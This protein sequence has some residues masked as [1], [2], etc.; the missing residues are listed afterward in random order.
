[1]STDQPAPYGGADSGAAR[2]SGTTPEPLTPARVRTVHLQRCKDRGERF[3]MLTSYDAM[4]AEIFD[5]TGIEVL[6]VGDSAANVVLGRESTLRISLEEM[7]VFTSAVVRSVSRA[8]VVVD[9][10]FGTYEASPE[11]AVGC[12]VRLMKESGAHAVKVEADASMADHVRAMVSA[13]I[14]VMAH[15]GFTPQSEHALGGYRIQGRGESGS[16]VLEDA[17]ALEAAGA[18]A[19][20]LEMVP[21]DVAAEVDQ[22]LSVPT[23]GIGAGGATTGQV[24]VWQDMLGLT[25]G[26]VPKFVRQY[27]DLRATMTEAVRT[28]RDEVRSGEFPTD[29]HVY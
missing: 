17:L 21:A 29:Q 2:P 19:V 14:P 27:A 8:M 23:I 26:R 22:R 13:G 28:Y 6:L 10:P 3:S 4:T 15:V 24:L 20:L 9:A 16:Q 11:Q 5:E 1:M 18:F 25:S 7:I 12:G